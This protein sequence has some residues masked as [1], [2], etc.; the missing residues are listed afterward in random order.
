MSGI[1]EKR[2]KRHHCQN[3]ITVRIR[4]LPAC[5]FELVAGYLP[6]TTK[7]LFAAAMQ[8]NFD[9]VPIGEERVK[10]VKNQKKITKCILESKTPSVRK[11]LETLG[12]EYASVDESESSQIPKTVRD[13]IEYYY[14]T[15]NWKV[16]DFIDLGTTVASKLS[17]IDL[18]RI[19]NCTGANEHL[20]RINL[21][22]CYSI[23]GWG[24]A[25]LKTSSTL[26]KMDLGL[27]PQGISPRDLDEECSLEEDSVLPIID[28]IMDMDGT[29]GSS[30]KRFQ[31]PLKWGSGET[32]RSRLKCFPCTP[33]HKLGRFVDNHKDTIALSLGSFCCHI[34]PGVGRD[35]RSYVGRLWEEMK[36]D[37]TDR[38]FGFIDRD[39]Y[40]PV[41]YSL[42]DPDPKWTACQHCNTIFC[43]LGEE[44][45]ECGSEEYFFQCDE[46]RQVS[47]KPCSRKSLKHSLNAVRQGCDSGSMDDYECGVMRCDRCRLELCQTGKLDCPLCKGICFDLMQRSM[48]AQ[49]LPLFD[50]LCTTVE[51]HLMR[52]NREG[53][54]YLKCYEESED[55]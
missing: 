49:E 45:C 47:C 51:G 38:C 5:I 48:R 26:E 28:A 55:E 36:L 15:S 8:G 52:G 37:V 31:F 20:E 14:N 11:L 27:V 18:L 9:H 2:C 43:L 24:L 50:E 7:V 41:R 25:P 44:Y 6:K 13:Q 42:Y 40:D 16:L 39:S 53:I 22:Y 32:R 12:H 23:V 21:T 3:I 19:L 30:L 46:C 29:R 1:S 35:A 4:D 17:D 33:G 54:E 34:G 10:L